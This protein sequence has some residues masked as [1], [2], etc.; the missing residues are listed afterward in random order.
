[1]LRIESR[2]RH[3]KEP[4]LPS[5]QISAALIAALGPALVAEPGTTAYDRATSPENTS[6]TQAPAAV[7]TPGTA[8]ET[9]RCVTAVLATDATISVQPAG[10]GAGRALGPDTVLIDTS[11]LTTIGI[12][13]AART[14]TTGAGAIWADV[15]ERAQPHGLLGLSGTARDVGV[16]GYTFAGGVGWLVRPHGLASARLRTVDYVDGTGRTRRAAA[17]APEPV[18]RDALC[19]F[20]GR[21]PR[22]P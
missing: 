10:H 3:L 18:D 7:L 5:H 9:A 2:Q 22:R 15:Q 6:V 17:D 11:R 13:P 14:A 1:M 19:A 12:D 8:A 16:A 4:A 21:P 20:P